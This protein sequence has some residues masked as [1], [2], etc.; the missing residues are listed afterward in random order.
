MKRSGA[1]CQVLS[2]GCDEPQASGALVMLIETLLII[3]TKYK[4]ISLTSP[5]NNIID[6]TCP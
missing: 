1:D 4:L 3:F 2:A 6:C 5:D